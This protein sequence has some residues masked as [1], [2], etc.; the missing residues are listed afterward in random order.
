MK[1]IIAVCFVIVTMLSLLTLVGC[2]SQTAAIPQ[3]SKITVE[4]LDEKSGGLDAMCK[5]LRSEELI[6]ND[7]VKMSSDVIGAVKGYRFQEN[8][9]TVE[10]YE[11]DTANL[12]DK[13]KQVIDSVKNTGKFDMFGT[14]VSGQMSENGKYMMVYVDVKTEGDNPEQSNVDRKNKVTEIFNKQA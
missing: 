13:A 5:S 4:S 14:E 8:N 1:K 9:I 11:Y 7:G 2:G 3:E 10:L 12:N 6:P